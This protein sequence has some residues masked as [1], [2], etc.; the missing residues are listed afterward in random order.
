MNSYDGNFLLISTVLFYT[1]VERRSLKIF[2]RK[3]H[4]GITYREISSARLSITKLQNR[5]TV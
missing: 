4:S 1:A 3:L 5:C 2:C